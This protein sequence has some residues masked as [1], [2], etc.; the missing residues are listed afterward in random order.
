M[1][2]ADL[3]HPGGETP[4]QELH[5]T[6]RRWATTAQDAL[7]DHIAVVR[8]AFTDQVDDEGKTM[9][10]LG[11]LNVSCI[12]TSESALLLIAHSRTWDAELLIRSVL[13]GTYR[14]V[15]LCV[16]DERER[17]RR[18]IE[19][20]EVM[21]EA[22]RL[23][24]HARAE[25]LLRSLDPAGG[26]VNP[27]HDRWRPIRDLLLDAAELQA[28]KERFPA[29]QRSLLERRWSFTELVA[30]LSRSD[31]PGAPQF[32][33][34]LHGYTMSSALIHK[35]GEGV[36]LVMER[37]TRESD[38]RDAIELAHGARLISDVLELASL[39][40]FSLLR[41]RNI[42][43]DRHLESRACHSTLRSELSEAIA[44]WSRIEYAAP[45]D[46]YASGAE[47]AEQC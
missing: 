28:L 1:K 11:Q 7:H 37:A 34:M 27:T 25:A 4:R 13:E 15:A 8:D 23:R 29:K 46:G 39:R 20:W 5:S 42:P 35:S 32:S 21:P 16:R 30:S 45:Q 44:N 2:P 19:Y 41:L 10:V 47:G 3:T 18:V 43:Q 12:M 22:A 33:A 9:Y 17:L 6:L 24:Q 14:F 38:R 36:A 40:A 26:V 31:L